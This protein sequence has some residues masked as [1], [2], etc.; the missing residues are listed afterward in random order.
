[1]CIKKERENGNL[2]KL[3]GRERER[4]KQ[5]ERE[6]ENKTDTERECEACLRR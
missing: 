6:R 2:D 3:G 4:E 5:T 1:M